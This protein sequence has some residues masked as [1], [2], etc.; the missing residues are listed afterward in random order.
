[1]DNNASIVVLDEPLKVEYAN[2]YSE[3]IGKLGGRKFVL[4][5]LTLLITSFLVYQSKISD[6][7][8]QLIVLGVVAAYITG[9]VAQRWATKKTQKEEE[10]EKKVTL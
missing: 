10:D 2:R 9:N 7:V 1:M 5:L 6:L 4:A 3:V 8:Y